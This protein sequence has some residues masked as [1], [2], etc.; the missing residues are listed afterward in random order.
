[1]NNHQHRHDFTEAP[2]TAA[3]RAR[4]IGQQLAMPCRQKPVAE[5]INVAEQVFEA[6]G[7]T[8]G[9]DGLATGNRSSFRLRCY[10]PY[11][12]PELTLF[13]HLGVVVFVESTETV[14]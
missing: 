12:F 7:V 6:H 1:M 5:I 3:P 2:A 10:L 9:A 14:Q 13:K 4:A 11:P 8:P